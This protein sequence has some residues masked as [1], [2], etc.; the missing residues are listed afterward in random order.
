MLGHCDQACTHTGVE[1]WKPQKV[2]GCGWIEW[3]TC[4]LWMGGLGVVYKT[5]WVAIPGPT[6]KLGVVGLL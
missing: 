1:G 4:V 6:C 2:G 5:N 3:H